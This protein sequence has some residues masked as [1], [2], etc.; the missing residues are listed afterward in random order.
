[1]EVFF[2]NVIRNP[3][4]PDEDRFERYEAR[5]MG[6]RGLRAGADPL[7][8]V[9]Q[10]A[11]PPLIAR[12]VAEV[13]N[14]RS[15]VFDEFRPGS[16]AQKHKIRFLTAKDLQEFIRRN[17]KPRSGHMGDAGSEQD[18]KSLADMW[19]TGDIE[20][21]AEVKDIKALNAWLRGSGVE[22]G[23]GYR[24]GDESPFDNGT[25]IVLEIP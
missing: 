4:I 24:V 7:T 21:G 22:V 15:E 6:S 1:M 12:I 9:E 20:L 10:G 2:E 23:A 3:A 11:V 5:A 14:E 13:P 18:S 25:E 16:E 8:P 19:G 17:H